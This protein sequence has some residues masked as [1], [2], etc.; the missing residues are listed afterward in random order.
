MAKLDGVTCV[1]SRH[2]NDPQHTTYNAFGKD[3]IVIIK[4]NGILNLT[5]QM[6]F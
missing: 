6:I 2:L 4:V 3:Y 1:Q 5:E